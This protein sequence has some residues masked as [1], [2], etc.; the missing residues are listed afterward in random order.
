MSNNRL[1]DWLENWTMFVAKLKCFSPSDPI[2]AELQTIGAKL[3]HFTKSIVE[4]LI[5]ARLND[6]EKVSVRIAWSQF[7]CN[8]KIVHVTLALVRT[9]LEVLYFLLN[10]L[11]RCF[12]LISMKF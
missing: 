4:P 7:R 9:I 6:H 1:D 5:D 2:G 12:E 10:D 3:D 8:I 11:F